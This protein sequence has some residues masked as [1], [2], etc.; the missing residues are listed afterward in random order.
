MNHPSPKCG[1]GNE[2]LLIYS[3]QVSKYLVQSTF[4][5][6]HTESVHGLCA[7]AALQFRGVS[8]A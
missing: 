6:S 2:E 1:S 3:T 5:Q 7:K 4:L 8:Y